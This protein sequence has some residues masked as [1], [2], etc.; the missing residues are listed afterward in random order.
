MK[1]FWFVNIPFPAVRRRLGMPSSGGS[2]FWMVELL[3]SL[4]RDHNVSI[5]VAWSGR[6]CEAPFSFEEGGVVYHCAGENRLEE[7]GISTG[8]LLRHW[9][10]LIPSEKPDLV[11]FHG[12]EKYHA[13][14]GS[15]ID[16]PSLIEIQGILGECAK[17]FFGP[18]R[19]FERLRFRGLV[20]QYMSY[21][22][23]SQREVRIF[24]EGTYFSGRTAW[25]RDYLFS[26]NP[27]AEY[28]SCPR[29]VRREFRNS[30]WTPPKD[31]RVPLFVS[32]ASAK[33]LK[34]VDVLL[35]AAGS[36][37]RRGMDFRIALAGQFPNGGYGRYLRDMMEAL[38]LT[39]QVSFTGYA[40][41]SKLID[42]YSSASVFVLPSY[43]ENSPN[44]LAEAMC[45][46][47]PCVASSTGGILSM[48]E[49]G[50]TG[51]L[52]GRSDSEDLADVLEDLAT[53]PATA[54]EMGQR[55]SHVCRTLH[56]PRAV[57]ETMMAVYNS[58]IDRER[59][60]R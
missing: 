45:F 49:E 42:I 17:A 15:R 32:T 28:H 7:L 19:G 59:N 13:L 27:N 2:G 33:P 26:I 37:R 11:E 41:P 60:G 8:R 12:T 56:D 4:R 21:R 58:I 39:E 35:K 57:T 23:R 40:D 5:S 52:F 34:G 31:G 36:L 46:G 24:R 55:A 6:Q 1:L 16:M 10:T 3:E 50:V 29:I 20:R 14:L 9:E 51:R 22:I 44:A 43:I 38:G 48:I 54:A 53:D 18:L 25:D 47:L 30:L